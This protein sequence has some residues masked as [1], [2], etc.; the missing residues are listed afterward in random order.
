MIVFDNL[1]VTFVQ[2]ASYI[3]GAGLTNLSSGWRYMVSIGGVSPIRLPICQMW[4]PKSPRQL[5][6]HKK[7]EVA[8]KVIAHVR[9]DPSEQQVQANTNS[10]H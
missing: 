4:C 7:V 10:V 2:L 6:I 3:F 5:L 8:R 1:S 9:P